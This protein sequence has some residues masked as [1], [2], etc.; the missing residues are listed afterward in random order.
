MAVYGKIK[1]LEVRTVE[2]SVAVLDEDEQGS[3]TFVES[4]HELAE[5]HDR[6]I[7]IAHVAEPRFNNEISK[8]RVYIPKQVIDLGLID[9]DFISC[10]SGECE[11]IVAGVSDTYDRASIMDTQIHDRRKRGEGVLK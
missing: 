10:S 4:M 1:H 7:V 6:Y 8:V 11:F 2:D 3:I 9:K 5:R